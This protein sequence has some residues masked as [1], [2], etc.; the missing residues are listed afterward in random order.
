MAVDGAEPSMQLLAEA[1]QNSARAPE[2]EDDA[3]EADDDDRSSSLSE[4][5]DRGGTDESEQPDNDS[6]ALSEEDEDV[7]EEEEDEEDEEGE[8]DDEEEEEEQDADEVEEGNDTEAETE[9]LES[10]PEKSRKQRKVLLRAVLED[11]ASSQA[12]PEAD[13]DDARDL[14]EADDKADDDIERAEG[15]DPPESSASTPAESV[16]DQQISKTSPSRKRKRALEDETAAS[17]KKVSVEL[18]NRVADKLNDDGE[19]YLPEATELAND[20]ML[21]DAE[22]GSGD[23][24]QDEELAAMT[25][26]GEAEDIAEAVESNVDEPDVDEPIQDDAANSTRTEEDCKLCIEQWIDHA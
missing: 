9:R 4:I 26:N 25:T 13:D 8:E 22:A 5:D 24:S 23:E 11:N 10:S 12:E 3:K 18:A 14:D 1:A 6:V 17:L 19:D 15:A 16:A 2:G 7:D 21:V 20:E